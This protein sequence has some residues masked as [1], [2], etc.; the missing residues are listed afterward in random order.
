EVA[1]AYRVGSE[2]P[3]TSEPSPRRT[4]RRERAGSDMGAFYRAPFRVIQVVD[5][6]AATGRKL[7]RRAALSATPRPPAD[8]SH[9]TRAGVSETSSAARPEAARALAQSAGGSRSAAP[10]PGA[11]RRSSGRTRSRQR[12]TS[13][14]RGRFLSGGAAAA[15]ASA[16]AA[17]PSCAAPVRDA[18]S[19]P[20]RATGGAR[21]PG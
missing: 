8:A 6:M 14:H 9:A 5:G 11:L 21:A 1:A 10:D 15:R 20:E 4:A 19:R 18:G 7:T 3:R 16:G 2:R 17:R 13:P 12:D